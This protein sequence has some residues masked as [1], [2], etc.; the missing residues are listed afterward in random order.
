M[1]LTQE[2]GFL[3]ANCCPCSKGPR[4]SF[5][6]LLIPSI[7][8]LKEAKKSPSF[9]D[10]AEWNLTFHHVISGPWKGPCFYCVTT[11]KLPSNYRI[12]QHPVN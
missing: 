4:L 7:S 6:Q 3:F 1:V 8:H 11:R 12:M 10:S 9:L 5:S 2:G